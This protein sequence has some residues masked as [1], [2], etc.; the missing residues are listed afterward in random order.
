MNLKE[1]K[2]SNLLSVIY[3]SDIDRKETLSETFYS[4]SKQTHKPDFVVI[5]STDMSEE[6][7]QLLKEMLDKPTVISRSQDKDGKITENIIE[8]TDAINYTLVAKKFN[9]FSEI[10]NYGF[11]LADDCDYKYYSIIEKDDVVGLHWYSKA[12]MYDEDLNLDIYLPI[13]RNLVNGVFSGLLNE[14]PWAEGMSEEAGK[15]DMNLLIRFNCASPIGAVYKVE[16][17]KQY[18]EIKDEMLCPYKESMKLTHYY[19]F[20]LRMV[21]NDLKAYVIPRI[22]Y[23]MRTITNQTFD[24]TSSKIPQNLISIPQ[25]NGGMSDDEARYWIELTKKEYFFDEDRNK[26]YVAPELAAIKQ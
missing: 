19:E 13:T 10:F 14:A 3:I 9:I 24:H 26:V 1:S 25:E 8:S 23:E 12:V 20:F 18:T 5:Y 6:K 7:V 15:L 17:I 21:Y 4:I 2:K 22:G 16:S 11:T